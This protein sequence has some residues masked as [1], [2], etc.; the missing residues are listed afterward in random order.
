M[1][2]SL[3]LA[4]AVSLVVAA[5]ALATEPKLKSV[6]CSSVVLSEAT[7]ARMTKGE[8]F[9]DP[10]TYLSA[11]LLGGKVYCTDDLVKLP[12]AGLGGSFGTVMR[13]HER[14][15]MDGTP[16]RADFYRGWVELFLGDRAKSDRRPS[17]DMKDATYWHPDIICRYD[18]K[19]TF[20]VQ[21]T[22]DTV[23]SAV[24]CAIFADD[25]GNAIFTFTEQEDRVR[26]TKKLDGN[27]GG[28]IML[29]GK[30]KYIAVPVESRG[31]FR[32]DSYQLA[33]GSW[34][35]RWKTLSSNDE[36]ALNTL[37]QDISAQDNFLV[38]VTGYPKR[39]A[40]Y[41]PIPSA[42]LKQAAPV[43]VEVAVKML[44]DAE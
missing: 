11:P 25:E 33:F 28:G 7:Q 44:S 42:R 16:Y 29:P 19:G 9:A 43:M 23:T 2:L 35:K 32:M 8:S 3:M 22:E 5:P 20:Q 31:W 37:V 34:R 36:Q 26:L 18:P 12:G 38:S 4:A 40:S 13:L 1:R 30:K 21:W 24:T 14:G 41:E 27:R 15:T 10:E 6:S 17:P 39:S